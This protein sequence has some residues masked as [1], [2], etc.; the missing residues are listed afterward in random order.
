[1]E[2]FDV[3]DESGKPTGVCV[4]RAE[5]HDKGILHRTAHVWIVRRQAGTTEVLLQRRSPEKDSYPNMY[6]TSSAG[7]ISAG[8]EPEESAIRELG[9]ELGIRATPEDLTFIGTFRIQ[10]VENF[11]GKPFRDNEFTYVY[12]YGHPVD[13]KSLTLQESEVS[14][15]EWF[16]LDEVWDEIQGH[17]ARFCVPADG[18]KLLKAYV[19]RA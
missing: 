5:A 19:G 9:E 1:M 2:Y 18:L 14:G 6:D 16:P 10:Y 7:H 4:S 13:A 3:V 12:V 11:H 8:D 15:V 17:S